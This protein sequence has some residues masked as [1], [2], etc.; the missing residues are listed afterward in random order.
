[1]TAASS[2]GKK[3]HIIHFGGNKSKT[4]FVQFRTDRDLQLDI[5]QLIIPSLQV[6]M[7]AEEILRDSDRNPA[8][9]VPLNSL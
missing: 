2:T 8:L 5:P 1:M 9:K 4:E 3:N 6:N 7:S